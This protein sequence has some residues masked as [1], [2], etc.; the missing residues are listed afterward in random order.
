M[1][2][3]IHLEVDGISLLQASPRLLERAICVDVKHVKVADPIS[4][5]ERAG[6]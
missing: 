3:L 2:D 1:R 4:G 6:H 5:E